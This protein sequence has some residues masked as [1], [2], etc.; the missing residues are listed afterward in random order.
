MK[1]LGGTSFMDSPLSVKQK[2]G[3]LRVS[4]SLQVQKGNHELQR[5]MKVRSGG[6]E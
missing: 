6:W 2:E 1:I 4:E 5:V 3:K